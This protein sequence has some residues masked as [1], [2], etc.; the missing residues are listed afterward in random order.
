MVALSLAL[1]AVACGDDGG[2]STELT[3]NGQSTALALNEDVAAVLQKEKVK[4]TPIEP[5]AP[6]D[7]GAIQFPITGGTVDS[8]TLAG[9]IA[10]RGGL[11]FTAGKETLEITNFV[12]DTESGVLSATAGAAELPILA[13]DLEQVKKSTRDGA[14]VA[15]GVTTTLTDYAAAAMNSILGVTFF[16]EGLPL[17]ELTVTATAAPAVGRLGPAGPITQRLAPPPGEGGQ[18]HRRRLARAPSACPG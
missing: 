15:S 13:L 9:T 18:R 4:V 2:S 6:T 5:A 7:T 10:H 3:L 16:E 14:I 12:A 11:L 17:G 8:D 1:T